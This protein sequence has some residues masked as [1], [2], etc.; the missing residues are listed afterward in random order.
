MIIGIEHKKAQ[1]NENTKKKT[2]KELERKWYLFL[3]GLLCKR[4][5]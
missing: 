2:L 1:N 5:K 3:I 4:K